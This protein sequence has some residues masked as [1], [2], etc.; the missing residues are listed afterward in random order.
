MNYEI[1]KG[2]KMVD[3]PEKSTMHLE[4]CRGCAHDAVHVART[5]PGTCMTTACAISPAELEY[6]RS[7]GITSTQYMQLVKL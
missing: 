1:P 5:G 3:S 6:R 4:R 7:L 2:Y